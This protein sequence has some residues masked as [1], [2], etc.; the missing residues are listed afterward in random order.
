MIWIISGVSSAGKSSF[1][2]SERALEIT[3]LGPQTPIIFPF[4]GWEG[5]R[6][7]ET[8][9][10]F[11]YNMMRPLFFILGKHPILKLRIALC[12][13]SFL[14]L[15]WSGFKLNWDILIKRWDFKAD[16][17]WSEFC[18]L[19]QQREAVVL[20]TSA[21]MLLDRTKKREPLET[22]NVYNKK[23]R[24]KYNNHLWIN[25]YNQVNLLDIHKRWINELER[26]EITY[27]IFDSTTDKY[28]EVKDIRELE[29]LCNGRRVKLG[30]G[31]TRTGRLPHTT[32][33]LF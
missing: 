4:H 6:K 7:G 11:H 25:I 19:R 23:T 21:P 13:L 29:T 31:D 17:K 15:S 8:E 33:S 14:P 24:R 20:V 3:G 2:L 16:P 9:A 26:N 28:P 27:H 32:R 18:R 1:I 22:E 5:F 30:G 12:R 10:F